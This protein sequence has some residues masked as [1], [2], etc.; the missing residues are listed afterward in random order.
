MLG[1]VVM[2]M[3]LVLECGEIVP[4]KAGLLRAMYLLH[5]SYPT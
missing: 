1:V 2:L 4:E 3:T 5:Q